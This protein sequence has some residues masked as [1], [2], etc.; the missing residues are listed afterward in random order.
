MRV[1]QTAAEI[2]AVCSISLAVPVEI[3]SR[4][5]YKLVVIEYQDPSGKMKGGHAIRYN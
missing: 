2:K 3:C 5:R 4:E 1:L